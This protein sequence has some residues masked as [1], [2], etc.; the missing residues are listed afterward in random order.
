MCESDCCNSQVKQTLFWGRAHLDDCLCNVPLWA[1][2]QRS[3]SPPRLTDTITLSVVTSLLQRPHQPP[4]PCDDRLIHT[5]PDL[6]LAGCPVECQGRESPWKQMDSLVSCSLYV[7]RRPNTWCSDCLRI[8][9][10][11]FIRTVLPLCCDR[12]TLTP[13]L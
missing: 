12:V 5:W 10:V 7:G 1:S 9:Q 6:K 8:K 13:F 4:S 2:Q 11:F 3:R